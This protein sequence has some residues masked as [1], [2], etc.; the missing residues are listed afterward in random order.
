MEKVLLLDLDG[1]ILKSSCILEF[2]SHI[3]NKGVISHDEIH[4]KWLA[5]KK[6]DD[7]IREFA[8][9]FRKEIVGLRTDYVEELFNEFFNNF[10]FEYNEKIIDLIKQ[11][12]ANDFYCMIISGTIDFMVK[13]IA[14]HL[15]ID[16]VGSKYALNSNSEYTGDIDIPMF[17]QKEK[18]KVIDSILNESVIE[19][20][21]AGDTTS[22]IPIALTSDTFYLVD[23][24][25]H[26]IKEYAKLD[27]EYV[28]M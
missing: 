8:E 11:C 24:N 3:I 23:P 2:A 19:V 14:E 9:H 1:T 6:N 27:I 20:I 7:Y 28:L 12:K 10:K 22:D 13:R 21:G 18:Q 15:G 25:I 4:Y 17:S 5:N 26:T 16:G